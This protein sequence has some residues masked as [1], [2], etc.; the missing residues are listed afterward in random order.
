M[1][2]ITKCPEFIKLE[3]RSIPPLSWTIEFKRD[4]D[5]IFEVLAFHHGLG[6]ATS[7]VHRGRANEEH[8]TELSKVL[9]AI[10]ACP[11]SGNQ[12][13][14]A[15]GNQIEVRTPS[16]RFKFCT[17]EEGVNGETFLHCLQLACSAVLDKST[18]QRW[19]LDAI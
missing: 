10:R 18:F 14:I 9:E 2:E 6:M 5:G 1:I 13:V 8:V 19:N 7:E 3:I 17:V 11:Q 4:K 16:G 12:R 15:D